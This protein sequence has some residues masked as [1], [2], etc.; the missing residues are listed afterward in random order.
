MRGPPG[1]IGGRGEVPL[2]TKGDT[3]PPG[4]NLGDNGSKGSV[5]DICDPPLLGPLVL[6]ECDDCDGGETSAPGGGYVLLLRSLNVPPGP[7]RGTSKL[8]L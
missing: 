8:Y 2:I 7:P 6:P 1:D 3:L 4:D 5:G